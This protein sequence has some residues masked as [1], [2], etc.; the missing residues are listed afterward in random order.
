[1][2]RD[3]L[4][5]Y[6]DNPISLYMW[7]FEGEQNNFTKIPSFQYHFHACANIMEGKIQ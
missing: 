7:I 3:E 5:D 1:M 6:P 4:Q 2:V